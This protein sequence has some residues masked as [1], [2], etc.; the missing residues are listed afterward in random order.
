[1]WK[2][3]PVVFLQSVLLV[4]C[5]DLQKIALMRAGDFAWSWRWF[6]RFFTDMYMVGSGLCFAATAFLW[7][8]MLK[9][10]PFSMV[11]L[12]LSL[13]YVLGMIAA[14]LFFHEQIPPIR[15]IGIALIIGGCILIAR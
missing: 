15:W 12:M 10:F 3:I 7:L 1:M 14:M 8:Y 11:Y 9:R 5:Q 6:L 2:L 4:A 13:A